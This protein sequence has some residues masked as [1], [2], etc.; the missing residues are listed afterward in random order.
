MF[1]ILVDSGASDNFVDDEVDDELVPGLQQR[2]RGSEI[3][4]KPKPLATAGNEKAFATS[5]GTTR[6][7]VINPSDQP[8]SVRHLLS[9]TM[10]K[11]GVIAI[12]RAG[13]L[14]LQSN[15]EIALLLNR[16]GKN[17]GMCLFDVP[18]PAVDSKTLTKRL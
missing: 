16:H 4:D 15:S 3:L 5:T 11:S 12:L 14:H 18:L 6:G 7:Q 17:A 8:I 13:N 1:T 2:M 9:V 10:M